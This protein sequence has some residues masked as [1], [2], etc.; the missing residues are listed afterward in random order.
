MQ[1]KQRKKMENEQKLVEHCAVC[2]CVWRT[3]VRLAKAIA[4]S[5]KTDTLNWRDQQ[6][7]A[8]LL[9]RHFFLLRRFSVRETMHNEN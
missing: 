3:T 5:A 1:K 8:Q 7:K 6:C 9:S 4:L 2:V